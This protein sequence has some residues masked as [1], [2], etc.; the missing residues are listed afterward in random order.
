MRLNIVFTFILG[1]ILLIGGY[2]ILDQNSILNDKSNLPVVKN[3]TIEKI[4]IPKKSIEFTIVKNIENEY[5]FSGIFSKEETPKI[6]VKNLNLEK[7]THDITINSGLA[8]N[9]D[10]ISLGKK[11]FKELADNYVEG[12]ILYKNRKLLIKGKVRDKKSIESVD[13]ILLYS[14]INSFNATDIYVKPISSSRLEDET[15]DIISN[16]VRTVDNGEDT[17]AELVKPKIIIKEKIVYKEPKVKEKI[18]IK[19]KEPKVK[20]KIVIKYKEPKVKEKIVIKYV[21]VPSKNSLNDKVSKI[22]KDEYLKELNSKGP[23]KNIMELPSVEMVDMNIEDKIKKGV[24]K[25]LKTKKPL[26]ERN[27]VYIPST[28]K[29]IDKSIPWAN[30]HEMDEQLDGIVYDDVV[31]SP[32]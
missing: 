11:L 18:V 2:I 6:L 19:Y 16:L 27:T 30:L 13:D 3:I 28:E 14:T 20:E 25:A 21:T 12:T 7:L 9:K 4:V 10:I 23:D 17:I 15:A 24:V 22:T 32:Y 1:M 26:V 29:K 8:Y 5:T 31:A